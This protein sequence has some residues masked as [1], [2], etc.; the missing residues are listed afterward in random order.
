MKKLLLWYAVQHIYVRTLLIA[1]VT[2]LPFVLCFVVTLTIMRSQSCELMAPYATTDSLVQVRM[3][4]VKTTAMFNEATKN[5]LDTQYKVLN[6]RKQHYMNLATTFFLNYY[7]ATVVLMLLSCIGGVVLFVIIHRGWAL[8]GALLRTVFL[9]L[10][11]TATFF[12]FFP[13]V[14]KQE[15]NFNA[16]LRYYMEYTKAEIRVLQTMTT[17]EKAAARSAVTDTTLASKNYYHLEDSLTSIHY[18]TINELTTYILAMDVTK[19]KT[20]EQLSQGLG[21]ATGNKK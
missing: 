11:A 6:N 15:E 9:T 18:K 19:I 12:G 10:A 21:E 14:F 1:V 7:G 16:N 5:N 20:F 3:K 4:M 8:T 2:L 13:A 17:L